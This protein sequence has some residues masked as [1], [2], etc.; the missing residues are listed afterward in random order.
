MRVNPLR[1]LFDRLLT[2]W[3]E[4]AFILK[5]ASFAS[6]GFVNSLIDF[7]VF[8]IAVQYLGLPLIPANVLSWLVAIS[9]SF[10]MN[11]FI[12]FARESGRK[13]RWR[14]YLTFASVGVIGLLVNTTVLLL[15]V[16]LM[17]RLIADPVQQLAAAKACAILASFLVNFSLSNFV[18][19]R[20][21]SDSPS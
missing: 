17:P 5:A 19:F 16:R 20:R 3:H 11:S 1:T 13:L 14:A 10:A 15:A 2:A 21:R 6:V 8:W 9:N 18:V 12:T 4:R 7:V